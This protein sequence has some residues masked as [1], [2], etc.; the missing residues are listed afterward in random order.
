MATC[1]YD[2][3]CNVVVEVYNRTLAKI[4]LA[5]RYLSP[6]TITPL[7][8]FI[9][10]EDPSQCS[11][12]AKLFK[13]GKVSVV[14]SG[15]VLTHEQILNLWA[16]PDGDSSPAPSGNRFYNQPVLGVINGV[17]VNFTSPT[18]FIHSNPDLEVLLY[19][20]MRLEHGP[21]ND[22]TVTESIPGTGYDLIALAFAPI[23]GDKLILD[24]TPF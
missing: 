17:N 9:F 13:E 3:E 20:G 10:Q 24:F 11:R 12:L 23:A 19:N 18:K 5:K 2:K 8:Y 7:S 15:N 22:Y 16:Y 1:N 6:K 14:I 4:Q 21:A